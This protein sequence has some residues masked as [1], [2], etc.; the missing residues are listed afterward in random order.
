MSAADEEFQWMRDTG[1]SDGAQDDGGAFRPRRVSVVS[2]ALALAGMLAVLL[3]L[4]SRILSGRIALGVDLPDASFLLPLGGVLVALA[5]VWEAVSRLRRYPPP[6]WRVKQEL[7]FVLVD[8]RL[9]PPNRKKW[10][11][12]GYR[13]SRPRYDRD[14]GT[15]TMRF[16]VRHLLATEERLGKAANPSCFRYAQGVTVKPSYDKRERVNG[17][18]LA[19][20]YK[21]DSEAYADALKKVGRC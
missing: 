9:L 15:L 18:L 6:V 5:A 3:S 8:A 14:S 1:G 16:T 17:W 4:L 19:V 10:Q 13:T 21:T 2:E 7:A 12:R 20:Q 11:D